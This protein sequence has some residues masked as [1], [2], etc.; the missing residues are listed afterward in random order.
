MALSGIK[1]HRGLKEIVDNESYLRY[2]R[3]PMG[4]ERRF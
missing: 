3:D 4:K 2:I 1:I